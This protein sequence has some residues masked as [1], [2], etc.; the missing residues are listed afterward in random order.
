MQDENIFKMSEVADTEI[1]DVPTLNILLCYL[2]YKIDKPVEVE[3][4]YE[5]AVSLKHMH[6]SLIGIS[7]S[8][9]RLDILLVSSM[10]RR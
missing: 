3:H 10:S 1:K 2:L 7:L 4:L 6:R 8:S 9:R 5:I